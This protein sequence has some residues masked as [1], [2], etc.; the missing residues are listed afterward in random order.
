MTSYLDSPI[1]VRS[2]IQTTCSHLIATQ[3]VRGNTLGF[4]ISLDSG[5]TAGTSPHGFTST[6]PSPATV[7]TLVVDLN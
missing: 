2:P 5:N 7:T 6:A 4:W 1:A 3:G